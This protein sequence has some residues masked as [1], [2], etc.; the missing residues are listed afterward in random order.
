VTSIPG[1]ESE[2][3]WTYVVSFYFDLSFVN[4]RSVCVS[5][6]LWTY[7]VMYEPLSICENSCQSVMYSC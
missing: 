7:V 1:Y 4:L 3:Y 6:K 2:Y 5:C